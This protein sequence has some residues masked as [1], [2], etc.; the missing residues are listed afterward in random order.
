M[1]VEKSRNQYFPAATRCS[2]WARQSWCK[3][4]RRETS[5]KSERCTSQSRQTV[6]CGLMMM[7]RSIDICCRKSREG[8]SA[9]QQS[10]GAV[11]RPGG[12]R[13]EGNVRRRAAAVAHGAIYRCRAAAEALQVPDQALCPAAQVSHPDVL[14]VAHVNIT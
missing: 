12:P 10:S 9:V 3:Q 13:A 2:P 1:Q 4:E 8:A 11:I 5:C 7:L 6:F 14:G